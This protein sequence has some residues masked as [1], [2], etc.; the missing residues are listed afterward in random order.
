[1]IITMT[2]ISH[3][4]NNNTNNSNNN[5][6]HNDKNEKFKTKKC[7]LTKLHTTYNTHDNTR[8]TT[9]NQVLDI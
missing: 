7:Y 6:N 1:M 9:I 3:N 4:H 8:L 2:T 5:N